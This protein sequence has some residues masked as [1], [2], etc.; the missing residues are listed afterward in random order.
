M[1]YTGFEQ[2]GYDEDASSSFDNFTPQ[3]IIPLHSDNANKIINLALKNHNGK[4]VLGVKHEE[5]AEIIKRREHNI[6]S[7]IHN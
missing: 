6:Y 1:T 5:H 2:N 7:I 3:K 4:L